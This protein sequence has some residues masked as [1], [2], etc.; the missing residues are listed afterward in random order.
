MYTCILLWIIASSMIAWRVASKMSKL[1]ACSPPGF[2]VRIKIQIEYTGRRVCSWG[3][4]G[5]RGVQGF[6]RTTCISNYNIH[7]HQY[8]Y[9]GRRQDF[10]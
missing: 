8:V 4:G 6:V 7:P 3:G 5:V 1:Y 10:S 9:Q 2:L